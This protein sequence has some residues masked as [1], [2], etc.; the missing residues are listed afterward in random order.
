MIV[1]PTLSTTRMSTPVKPNFTTTSHTMTSIKEG[2]SKNEVNYTSR[3]W[4]SLKKNRGPT[5]I[6]TQYRLLQSRQTLLPLSYRSF[7]RVEKQ[8]LVA[9]T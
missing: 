7:H 9:G 3:D 1:L 6:G 5:G 2:F 8:V 4:K